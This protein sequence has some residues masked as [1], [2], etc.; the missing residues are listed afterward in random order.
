MHWGRPEICRA[1]GRSPVLRAGPG[2]RGGASGGISQFFPR[3]KAHIY[4]GEGNMGFRVPRRLPAIGASLLVVAGAFTSIGA[5]I[6]ATAGSA[7]AD[8]NQCPASGTGNPQVDNMVGAS[9]TTNGNTVTY[10]FDSFIDESSTGGVPGLIAYCIYPT[11]QMQPDSTTVAAVGQ[12]G[13]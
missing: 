4:N 10:I 5:A 11:P 2:R 6:V 1:R 12:D 7:A 13:S 3:Y 9:F 8:T